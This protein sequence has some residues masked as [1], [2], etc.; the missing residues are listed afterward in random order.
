MFVFGN[1]DQPEDSR[2]RCRGP[3]LAAAVATLAAA[4]LALAGATWY[5][6]RGEA[7]AGYSCAFLAGPDEAEVKAAE[8]LCH[9]KAADRF[10]RADI[11]NPGPIGHEG[12]AWL[13]RDALHRAFLCPPPGPVGCDDR[14]ALRPATDADVA[15]ARVALGSAGLP[16]S[17][18]RLAAGE[19]PAPAGALVYSLLMGDGCV[20]GYLDLASGEQWY[21][22]AGLLPNGRCLA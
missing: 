21:E 2:P 16:D 13:M 17:V 19:D 22:V 8:E 15:T 6:G 20:V 11:V 7:T 5:A 4:A 12:T 14:R 3:W 1:S 9:R 10:R 18:V